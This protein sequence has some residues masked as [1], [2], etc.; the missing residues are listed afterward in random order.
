MASFVRVENGIV[1]ESIVA[2][3]EFIDSGAVGDPANWIQTSRNTRG[4]VHYG[5][6]GKPDG[7]FALRGNFAGIG[8]IYDAQR[9]IFYEPQP[10]P[11]WTFNEKTISWD[12]PVP[13][14]KDGNFYEWDESVK[15]WVR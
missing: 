6:D 4:G 5:P 7:G 12:S 13:Y 8:H 15:N 11:S 3:Q 10:Y 1:V 2:D 14:P 9:D